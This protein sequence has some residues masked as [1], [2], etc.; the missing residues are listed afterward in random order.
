MCIVWKE[1]IMGNIA[2]ISRFEFKMQ[3]KNIGFWLVLA[4]AVIMSLLDNAPTPD[5]MKRL[6]F[7]YDQN[8]VVYRTML[9]DGVILLFGMAFL[10]AGRINTDKKK[11]VIQLFM[12][13]PLSQQQYVLGKFLGNFLIMLLMAAL[14]LCVNAAVHAIFNTASFTIVPYITGMLAIAAPACLL[15]AACC[16]SIPVF[17]DVRAFYIVLG[18][19]FLINL[20]NVNSGEGNPCYLL[21]GDM[22]H[23][24]FTYP[25]WPPPYASMI[26]NLIFL[27][28]ISACA[29]ILMLIPNKRLWR[30]R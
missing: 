27:L 1:R 19:Y 28:G 5:N 16:I 15:I 24:V 10:I 12:A 9:Q 26:A 20:F 7:L 21:F 14:L 17:L 2:A 18:I 8:Y 22:A 6:Q 25:G 23:T 4:L 29:L 11:G 3:I 30:E 13:A